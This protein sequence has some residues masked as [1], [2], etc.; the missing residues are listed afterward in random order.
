LETRIVGAVARSRHNGAT[1]SA[2]CT[3]LSLVRNTCVV[4]LSAWSCAVFAARDKPP[5]VEVEVAGLGNE[6]KQNVEAHLSIAKLGERGKQPDAQAAPAPTEESVRRLHGV[7]RT[8]IEEAL[9]PFGYYGPAVSATLQRTDRGWLARYE[10]DPGDPT[11]LDEVEIRVLGDGRD[12]PGLRAALA[13]IELSAGG[14]L[15]HPR[16]EAAKQR[17]FNAAYEAGYLDVAYQRAEILVR[18]RERKADIHLVLETGPKYYFGPLAI[19]QEIL[20]PGLIARFVDIGRGDPFDSNRLIALQLALG[21]SGYFSNATVDVMRD[22]AVDRQIPVTV[23]TTPRKTQEYTL[24]MGYGTDTGPRLSLGT[25]FRRINRRGHRFKSD[26]RLSGISTTVAAEY[27]VPVKDV[28][29]DTLSY[30]AQLGTQELG[31]LETD[32]VSLGASWNDTWRGLQR[33]LYLTAHREDWEES[34][35]PFSANLLFP[36]INLRSQQTADPLFTRQ[37][38]SWSADIRGGAEALASATSFLR[39]HATG[40]IVRPLGERAR[41]LFRSEYGAI[42]AGDF[43]RLP[44]SQRFFAGGDRSVRGYEYEQLGPEDANGATVGGRYL[45]TGTAEI[46]YLFYGNYG[47][48]VFVDAGNAAND[49]S[50]E[51][52]RSVGIGFRWRSPV[53]MVRID[54][55]HPLD[56]PDT[57]YRLHLSI[58]SDL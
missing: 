5:A 32:Q 49:P 24:G 15:N 13:A 56:D 42:D 23:H 16:Y 36:G 19:E 51:L 41:L 47:A 38:H 22:Q 33:R 40:A 21:D 52:K 48:A 54:V 46:D 3:A 17:L 43:S 20:D 27:Q 18:P 29:T 34:G 30:R 25:E 31:D 2:L 10:V 37:G 58:G 1:L 53:G 28:A 14:V 12:E 55:A 11:L 50:P 45:V 44:P 4:V 6:I 35:N 7:A 8:E 57:D 39:V 26:L 9:Q